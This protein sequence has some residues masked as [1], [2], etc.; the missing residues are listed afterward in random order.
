MKRLIAY[1][2]L[3]VACDDG[4]GP[5][6]QLD[7]IART[8]VCNAPGGKFDLHGKNLDKAHVELQRVA[9]PVEVA[10]SDPVSLPTFTHDGDTLHV[11]VDGLQNGVFDVT[12]VDGAER[13]NVPRS[14]AVL[15]PP[16]VTAIAPAGLCDAQAA[17]T[18]FI[19][20]DG[21]YVVRTFAPMVSIRDAQGLE[22]L[23][24][25]GTPLQC[26]DAVT[27]VVSGVQLCNAVSVTIPEAA[28]E[29][30]VYYAVVTNPPP[31][32]CSS[33]EMMPFSIEP[34]PIIA[35]AQTTASL[36]QGGGSLD[37]KGSGFLAGATVALA[38]GSPNTSMVVSDSEIT[39][40]FSYEP[41][42]VAGQQLSLVV[43]N[44]DGCRATAVQAITIQPGPVLLAVDPRFTYK[45]L[46][47][48]LTLH[49]S[50]L[51]ASGIAATITPQAGGSPVTLSVTAD[52]VHA[53]RVIAEVPPNLA[54]GVYDLELH[55]GSNCDAH[56]KNALVISDNLTLNLTSVHPSFGDRTQPQRITIAGSGMVAGA[57]AYLAPHDGSRIIPIGAQLENDSLF[58][59]VPPNVPAN[60]YDI[61]V[62]NPDGSVG[63]LDD[64]ATRFHSY[65]AVDGPIPTITRVAPLALE[66]GCTN[67]KITVDGSNFGSTPTVENSC[68]GSLLPVA[69]PTP[70]H[71]VVDGTSLAALMQGNECTL[72][73]V[74]NDNSS[75][76]MGEASD[77]VVIAGGL[78]SGK[79]GDSHW[80]PLTPLGTARRAA[81]V[82]AMTAAPGAHFLY[83]LG[84]DGG[85]LGSPRSDGEFASISGNMVSAWR[86]LARNPLGQA[87]TL[88]GIA[89]AGR[90][91]FLVG[92]YNGTGSLNRVMRGELLDPA[93]A[94]RIT[95]LG[96]SFDLN[97]RGLNSGAY[98]YRIA[99]Q[100][101]DTDALDPGGESLASPTVGINL[102]S[103]PQGLDVQLT[104]T[105]GN[106]AGRAVTGWRVYRGQAP[107]LL[108][109][110]VDLPPASGSFTDDGTQ[111]NA[112]QVPQ[113]LG[114]IG[115]FTQVGIPQLNTARA[116]AGVTIATDA[117]LGRYFLYAG[118]GWSSSGSPALPATYE[119]LQI[120]GDGKNFTGTFTQANF[121]A[122]GRWL[123]G[124]WAATPERDSQMSSRVIYFGQG[125]DNLTLTSISSGNNIAVV[126]AGTIGAGGA[127]TAL[128]TQPFADQEYGY[129]SFSGGDALFMIGGADAN[130]MPLV[131][132]FTAKLGASTPTPDPWAESIPI[133]PSSGRFL[134][135]AAA[136]GAHLFLV[137]GSSGSFF[138]ASG[139]VD[140]GLY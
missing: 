23:N 112:S 136:D 117:T 75:G 17:Q 127:L 97:S 52:P 107:D 89:A 42:F 35:A 3:I 4:Q 118:F 44:P 138:S 47:T 84:G 98:Y 62:I 102:A 51:N 36:C 55:D 22:R 8:L 6:P 94:P 61:V 114:A 109:H 27:S 90:F 137:G 39:A 2:L 30:G 13:W 122:S 66:S 93:D 132:A 15:Q 131:T 87:T 79:S 99:A 139:E 7:Q 28:L 123:I 69:S 63:K 60:S 101:D 34:A 16:T 83:A 48:G 115:R 105:P 73:V 1:T 95:D 49:L 11:S 81:S 9:T 14:L 71:L 74:D 70:T 126:D 103:L 116:G 104:W 82:I 80:S 67:C 40:D 54:A 121:G 32:S 33:T 72:R 59:V 50:S 120:D 119:V 5:T 92:G 91:L 128:G 29:P 111:L 64:P 124:A 37:I 31:L 68:N 78:S 10:V 18:I 86:T 96:V 88:A 26:V 12:A 133:F 125:T 57:R 58:A 20:G 41:L 38:G 130:A 76:L 134:P 45:P 21:F 106:T 129:A 56:L 113:V 77:P 85:T 53:N 46:R 25:L 135:G 24:V 43:T 110:Y 108:D 65:R 100:F 19:H 140:V